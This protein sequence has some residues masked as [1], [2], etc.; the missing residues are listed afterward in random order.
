MI[1]QIGSGM[2][3]V[4]TQGQFVA[5][6]SKINRGMVSPGMVSPGIQNR[7]VNQQPSQNLPPAV[8]QQQ[9]SQV[10][11]QISQVGR[12]MIRPGMPGNF[13]Q[14]QQPPSPFSP[15]APQSPHDFPQ[16]PVSQVQ[17]QQ[18][19]TPEHFQRF[20][21]A[22]T[23]NQSQQPR[24]APS[25]YS[26]SPRND[27][28]PQHP[29]TPRPVFSTPAVRTHVYVP[30]RGNEIYANPQQQ[31]SVTPPSPTPPNQNQ[32]YMSPRPEQRSD[33]QVN[34]E[35]FVQQPEVNKQLRDLLQRQQQMKPINQSWNQGIKLINIKSKLV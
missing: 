29:A 34:N 9:P 20:E 4:N 26:T 3:V 10:P 12:S 25:G 11:G 19:Q 27:V 6:A 17:Q 30:T 1:N 18:P 33:S 16:S 7:L 23:F 15:Q 2:R 5:P 22:E 35:L 14:Q 32:S 28:F 21:N 13:V 24:P 31:Q 8:N